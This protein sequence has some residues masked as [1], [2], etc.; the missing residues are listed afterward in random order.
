MNFS[1]TFIDLIQSIEGYNSEANPRGMKVKEA[2]MTS[3]D[4]I[5]SHPIASFKD[6]P[7]NFKYF[8]GELAWY[9]HRDR[10][11]DYITHFSKFWKGLTNPNSNEINS[12]YGNLVI[13]NEQLGWV[14]DSL[15]KDKNSRQAIMFFNR[16]DFQFEDNKDFVCTLYSNFFI[17]NN[18][19][20]M[21][22]QM[23]SNDIFFGLTFDA[24]FF[25]FL[26]QSV[27]HILK[28]HYPELELG[29]YFN[30]VDNIHF[31]ERHFKLANQIKENG[32]DQE[33]TL[34]LK[35][36]MIS[37]KNGQ[38]S[39]TDSGRE[40]IDRIDSAIKREQD[41]SET[42]YYKAILQDYFEI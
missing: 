37:Y 16:P 28:E 24:P 8:A 6:R 5:P 41:T 26:H 25:S 13:N 3:F 32:I 4:I 7:F 30:F 17:R 23:R 31:Y 39:I 14:I 1:Q 36:P 20:H 33:Y 42:E 12:N 29:Y 34:I 40:Y 15:V 19:L 18:K 2:L 35:K 21:K 22:L 10:D 27:Y 9:L 38:V 11:V